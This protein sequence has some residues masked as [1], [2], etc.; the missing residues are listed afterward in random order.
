MGKYIC[1]K[2]FTKLDFVPKLNA[3]VKPSCTAEEKEMSS[4]LFRESTF[5]LFD[6]FLTGKPFPTD[7]TLQATRYYIALLW[8]MIRRNILHSSTKSNFRS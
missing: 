4:L 6:Y 2:L 1:H 3:M 5:I 7:E 8:K